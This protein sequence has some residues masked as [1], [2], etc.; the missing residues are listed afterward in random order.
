MPITEVYGNTGWY[1]G[2]VDCRMVGVDALLR[3]KDER[4]I[5]PSSHYA[6]SSSSGN[7]V[8]SRNNRHNH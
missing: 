6:P 3:W 2:E 1:M 5:M 8:S 4:M 7:S